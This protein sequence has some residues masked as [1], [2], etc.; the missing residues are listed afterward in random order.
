MAVEQDTYGEPLNLEVRHAMHTSLADLSAGDLVLVA[1]SGGADSVALVR[2]AVH[3]AHERQLRIGAIVINHQI[4]ANSAEVAHRAY[5]TCLALSVEFAEV[6]GVDVQQGPGSGGIEAAARHAR[7]TALE[8]RAR[9]LDAQAILLGHSRD[10]QAETVLL[11]LARGSGARSLAGMRPIDGLYRRPFLFLSRDLVRSVISDIQTYDDPHNENP[12][13]ARVRVRHNVLPMLDRE[14]GP[15]ISEALARTADMLR[16][17]ADYLDLMAREALSECGAEVVALAGLPSAVR[18]RVLRLLA[19]E[20]GC[21]VN[22]LTR[23]HIMSIDRLITH[24]HGQGPLNLPGAVN[25]ERAHGRLT[26][27][28]TR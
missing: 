19:I 3:V 10:D 27:Y 5:E 14:L 17:D 13:F 18:T 25:V 12:D 22:D 2:S 1:C 26:F 21:T 4:Q 9:E 11:G 16:D 24:W 23:E 8:N 15:R 7:R 6:I 28:T 20:Q